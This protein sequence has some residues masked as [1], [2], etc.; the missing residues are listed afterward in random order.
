MN[1]VV[2]IGGGMA[3]LLSAKELLKD[4]KSCGRVTL[5]EQSGRLGG[6]VRAAESPAGSV[7]DLGAE[8]IHGQGTVLTDLIQELFGSV[9]MEEIFVT[10]HADGGPSPEPTQAGK[11]GMY[12]M[13]G[14]LLRYDDERIWPLTKALGQMDGMTRDAS[15]SVAEVLGAFNLSSEL[16]E[17]AQASYGNTVGA[18]HDDISLSVL[19]SFEDYWQEFEVDGDLSL[20]FLF[21]LI[22]FG[23]RQHANTALRSNA[24]LVFF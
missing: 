18:P 11:Y 7:V 12:Y 9:E 13:G 24:E 17:L 15:T 8:F 10:S 19:A 3:G 4:N 20:L 5:V 2:I 16:M 22:R 6:R 23:G 21:Y 1:H 14:Q